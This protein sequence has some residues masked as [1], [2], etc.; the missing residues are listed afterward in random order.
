MTRAHAARNMQNS[1][2]GTLAGAETTMW[3][4]VILQA[5]R[6]A[7]VGDPAARAWLL[8]GGADFREVCEYAGF[9]HGWVLRAAQK[10][11]SDGWRRPTRPQ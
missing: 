11:Q 8:R 3:R 1:T 6:D 2:S 10:M 5:V 4:A 9:D 7:A